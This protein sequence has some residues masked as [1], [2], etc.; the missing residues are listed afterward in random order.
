[1]QRVSFIWFAAMFAML[2]QGCARK[3]DADPEDVSCDEY[4]CPAGECPEGTVPEE[5][6][7]Q[8]CP[9]CVDESQQ[10]QAGGGA[11]S[12]G[13]GAGSGGGTGG[14]GGSAGG[15]GG[16]GGSGGGEAGE[17]G[18]SGAGGSPGECPE[19]PPGCVDTCADADG[20][21]VDARGVAIR[22]C[23]IVIDDRGCRVVDYTVEPC[24]DGR[25]C[26]MTEDG[27]RCVIPDAPPAG[28]PY[29]CNIGTRSE[30]WCGG[31]TDELLPDPLNDNQPLWDTCDGC[32]AVCKY[33]GT[34]SEGWYSECPGSDRPERLLKF[35]TCS[36]E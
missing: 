19:I 6:P 32:N 11:G 9:V 28:R 2:L 7:G 23:D 5:V 27:V 35:E 20:N 16:T 29:C 8:C 13:G 10:G 4:E 15:A 24:G 21:P 25:V 34:Y 30:G 36:R 22:R 12:G 31:G 18:T 26:V 3:T 33:I 1:M 17:G 14:A